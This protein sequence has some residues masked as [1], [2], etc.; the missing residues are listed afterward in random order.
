MKIDCHVHTQKFDKAGNLEQLIDS[1]TGHGIK[2]FVS[3]DHFKER[4]FRPGKATLDDYWVPYYNA[5]EAA[6]RKSIYVL[7][8]AEVTVGNNDY[9]IYGMKPQEFIGLTKRQVLFP[10]FRKYVN[11]Y[12]G[13]VVQA[14]PFRVKRGSFQHTVN[15]NI[16]GLEIENGHP[17]HK[18]NNDVAQMLVRR[19]EMIGSRGSDAHSLDAIGMAYLDSERDDDKAMVDFMMAWIQRIYK[20]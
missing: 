14:H 17:K 19:F 13:L 7:P 16:D 1:F 18:G 12:G 10:E 2:A 5:V 11:A 8:G 6:S 15:L 9:L 20:V 3:T 4:Y